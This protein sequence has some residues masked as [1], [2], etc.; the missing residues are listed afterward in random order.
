MIRQGRVYLRAF[1]EKDMKKIWEWK[2]NENLAR[3]ESSNPFI[4]MSEK[5][6]EKAY[7]NSSGKNCYAI[8]LKSN[9]ELIGEV[10]FWYPNI[11]NQSTVELGVSIEEEKCKYG[12]GIEATVALFKIIFNNILINRISFCIGSHNFYSKGPLEKLFNCDGII[13]NDRLI[14]GKYYDTYIYGF[15]R[16]DYDRIIHDILKL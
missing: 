8:C 5:E 12:Y 4:T 7:I 9:D 13:K 15:L 11:L 10:S 3:Y 2:N 14:D 16:K 6:I 1:E